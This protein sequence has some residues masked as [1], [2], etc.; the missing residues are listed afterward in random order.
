MNNI[1][2]SDLQ[3]N[4]THI[5]LSERLRSDTTPGVVNRIGRPNDLNLMLLSFPNLKQRDVMQTSQMIDVHLPVVLSLLD[6]SFSAQKT[7]FLTLAKN[8]AG[9]GVDQD[10]ASCLFAQK[11]L[12]ED[13][14]DIT[15]LTDE[16]FETIIKN[17]MKEHDGLPSDTDL[18]TNLKGCIH[19]GYM[20]AIKQIENASE[21]GETELIL[22]RLE[23][24]ILPPEIGNLFQL[25]VLA[26]SENQLSSLP[27]EIKK[28]TVLRDLYLKD[29]KLPNSKKI[30]THNA[31]TA[32]FKNYFK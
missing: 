10:L 5:S 20:D 8:A 29:N 1:N 17:F 18:Q 25:E 14:E 26:L 30:Y 28:L 4:H 23:L 12:K 11:Y 2:P 27:P 15:A 24:I 16:Q 32:F 21:N 22:S 31:I 7:A 3:S 9:D 19:Q 13:V 6:S